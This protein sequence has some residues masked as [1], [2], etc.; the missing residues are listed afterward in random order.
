MKLSN[1]LKAYSVQVP[2]GDNPKNAVG[3]LL[4]HAMNKTSTRQSA[5]IPVTADMARA[6]GIPTSTQLA[7]ARA[8][9]QTA[10]K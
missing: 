2:V 10:R 6:L 1:S 7:K 8:K 5:D 9:Q 3:G 4:N